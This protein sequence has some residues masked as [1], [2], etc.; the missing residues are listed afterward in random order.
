[1]KKWPYYIL[2]AALIVRVLWVFIS[3]QTLGMEGFFETDTKSYTS[4]AEN[5]REGRGYTSQLPSGEYYPEVSRTPGYPL[6]IALFKSLSS[7]NWEWWLLFF[8]I[9]LDGT[10]AY[11]IVKMLYSLGEHTAALLGGAYYALNPTAFFSVASFMTETVFTFFLFLGVYFTYKIITSDKRRGAYGIMAGLFWGYGTLVRPVAFYPLIAV[12][13]LFLLWQ[14]VNKNTTKAH[15]KIII[16]FLIFLTI[17]GG[18]IVRNGLV[19]N[20]WSISA[21]DYVNLLFYRA[22]AV[23]A[24]QSNSEVDEIV[25]EYLDRYNL[26]RKRDYS[27]EGLQRGK[28]LKVEAVE[29]IKSNPIT[30]IKVAFW[31]AMRLMFGDHETYISYFIGEKAAPYASMLYSSLMLAVWV[32]AFYGVYRRPQ[33][34]PVAVLTFLIIAVSAGWESYARFRVPL[35]PYIALAF[36]IGASK[37]LLASKKKIGNLEK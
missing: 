17:S 35:E 26:E 1:M 6:I 25:E 3:Y 29:I 18:W 7:S 31:G 9:A 2:L 8:Q 4:V 22:A 19:S 33:L 30:Y 32:F 36:G 11:L 16:P 10:V 24:V 21:I 34:L 15:Y 5:L 13:I 27:A 37:V 20:Y 28:E 14:V 12:L 23:E